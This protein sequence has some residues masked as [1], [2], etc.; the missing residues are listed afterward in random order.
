MNF[1]VLEEVVFKEVQPIVSG[2]T[3]LRKGNCNVCCDR[4]YGNWKSRRT[5]MEKEESKIFK[6]T[7]NGL[8]I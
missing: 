5:S 4:N 3:V 2:N 1:K 7:I 8:T 6:I